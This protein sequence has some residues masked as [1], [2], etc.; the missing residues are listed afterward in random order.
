MLDDENPKNHV[1]T[2][3]IFYCNRNS[4]LLLHTVGVITRT[5]PGSDYKLYHVFE[6]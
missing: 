2:G 1:V 5:S 3:V 4:I 6:S